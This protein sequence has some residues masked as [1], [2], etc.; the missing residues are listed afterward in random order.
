MGLN[1]LQDR[2]V[3]CLIKGQNYLPNEMGKIYV[4]KYFSQSAKN[5]VNYQ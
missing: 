2:S 4:N 5:D 3:F 1:A